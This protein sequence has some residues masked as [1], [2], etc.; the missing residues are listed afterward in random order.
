[1][2][3]F[4]LASL[5]SVL[6]ASLGAAQVP[7]SP[8]GIPAGLG[9]RPRP[10]S[11]PVTDR[12]V[13]SGFALTGAASAPGDTGRLF[14]MEQRGRIMILDLT[15][16][17]IVVT[18][19]LDIDS[20]VIG[21]GGERGL[22][23]LA[24]HPDYGSNGL[25]YVNYNR[26]TDGHTV[27]AEY[28]VTVDPAVADFAS[29]RI[30]LTISQP[31][32]NHNGGWLGFSPLDGYLYIATGDGGGACDTG[33][34]HT[35][36]TGNAQDITTNLLGKMLRIDPLGAVPYAVPPT[37]PF[38]GLTGDDEIW[39]YGLRNPWR[40]SFDRLTGDLYIGDVGQDLSEE[41][42]YQ[43]AASPGGENYG[44]RCREGNSCST[45]APSSCPATTGCTCPGSMP[46]LTPP[47][48]A[49]QHNA[50]PPP[51]GFVC[52][53][54]GGYVYRGSALPLLQGQYLFADFC[55]NAVWSI[56]VEGGVQSDYHDWTGRFSPSVDGFNVTGINSFAEDANGE[57]YILSSSAV[58][59]IVPKL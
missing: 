30:L 39:A 55:G 37:N 36:G 32:S 11:T 41:I 20:R 3:T 45:S 28:A 57:L 4:L 19:F 50:P 25:F 23:G 5:S 13:T 27:I 15:T 52:A 6:L 35:T 51:A 34:G 59:K 43:S 12:L 9:A 49:Y 10:D 54:T 46:S 38:V 56:R 48:H 58:F 53:V 17:T 16:N 22:L 8:T 31:Q 18:P 47:V 7:S 44:W 33:S 14:L 40:S 2:K 21:G 24:F 26:N 42:D 1:V 29:E